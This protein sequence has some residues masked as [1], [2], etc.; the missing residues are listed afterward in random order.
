MGREVAPGRSVIFPQWNRSL[1]WSVE[2]H[3]RS[4]IA[5]VVSK[6][7]GGDSQE[8]TVRVTVVKP[9]S[10]SGELEVNIAN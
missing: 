4:M 5:A 8:V 6:P 3:C 10:A 9:T 1:I 7:K 2:M